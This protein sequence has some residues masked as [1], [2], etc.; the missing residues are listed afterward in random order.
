MDIKEKFF[1]GFEEITTKK[2]IEKISLDLK[3]IPFEKLIWHPEENISLP[4]FYLQK[5]IKDLPHIN[6]EIIQKVLISYDPNWIITEQI[7]LDKPDFISQINTASKNDV[8]GLTIY[9][10]SKSAN[11]INRITKKLSDFKKVTFRGSNSDLK[12]LIDQPFIKIF[13]ETNPELQIVFGFNVLSEIVLNKI[14]DIPLFCTKTFEQEFNS[15]PNVRYVVIDADIFHNSG[16]SAVQE[17]GFTLAMAHGYLSQFSNIDKALSRME[18]V[19]AIGG[20]YF[21]EIAKIRT[22]KI[23]LTKLMK[24]HNSSFNDFK[25]IFIS[26]ITSKL[27]KTL[28]DPY[29]NMLRNTTEAMSA[30]I[31]GINALTVI[32]FNFLY[33]TNK[34]FGKRMARNVQHLLKYEMHLGEVKDMAA[35]SYYIEN[36]THQLG[37][38]SWKLFQET[39]TQGSFIDIVENGY[40]KTSIEQTSGKLISDF[41]HR[42]KILVGINNYPNLSETILNEIKQKNIDIKENPY[43]LS[44]FRLSSKIESLRFTIEQTFSE[45]P[46]AFL[47]TY[48]NLAIRRAKAG[49]ALNFLGSIGFEIIDNNGFETVEAGMTA[50]INSASIMC[51]V[52]SE[53]ANYSKIV[54]EIKKRLPKNNLLIVAGNQ[55]SISLEAKVDA[56]IYTG[57][58][59]LETLTDIQKKLTKGSKIKET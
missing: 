25:Q 34:D 15:Y 33:N 18:F 45:K 23:L 55:N 2:W 35:G 9:F 4:P 29:I 46:K 7:N 12:T 3:D 47:F 11:K 57:I 13:I 10:S 40:L 53:D 49:F 19:F 22:F 8:T 36:I 30:I 52:C 6:D 17:L 14:S 5:D 37:K 43:G 21:F 50:F 1:S 31:G 58:N 54:P 16:A 24:Q 42:K 38:Q 27:N 56:Y 48:G 32:P 51:I 39:L 20:N 44:Q 26:A 28:Y 59:M 41:N